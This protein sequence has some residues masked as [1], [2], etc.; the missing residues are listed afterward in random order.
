MNNSVQG[1]FW[2]LLV[3]FVLLAV[4]FAVAPLL[5]YAS[6]LAILSL[7]LV[8]FVLGMLLTVLAARSK[9]GR[10]LK[11]FLLLTGGAAT[12]ILVS[13]LIHNVLTGLFQGY[14]LQTRGGDEPFF[15]IL[16]IFILPVVY[17]VGV[18]GSIVIMVQARRKQDEAA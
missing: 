14:W 11:M 15:F 6:G 16:G 12:G 1:V 4:L 2:A 13:V 17:L 8:F 9:T 3:V 5:G 18:A 7:S 10:A